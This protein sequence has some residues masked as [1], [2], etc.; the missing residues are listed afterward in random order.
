[1]KRGKIVGVVFFLLFIQQVCALS[2]AQ[3]YYRFDF[4]PNMQKTLTFNVWGAKIINIS[5]IG[6]ELDPYITLEDPAPG[7][8]AR[9]VRLILNL[10]E[11]MPKPGQNGIE[12]VALEI[13][14][15]ENM[16]GGVAEIHTPILIQAPYPGVYAEMKLSAPSVNQGEDVNFEVLV[17]NLGTTDLNT[18]WA[19]VKV[20]D[21]DDNQLI[22][23]FDSETKAIPS[24]VIE[25]FPMTM[26]T[27]DMM[28][29]PYMAVGNVSYDGGNVIGVKKR[30]RIGHLYMGIANYTRVLQRGKINKVFIDVESQ[31][32]S[33]ID[34]VYAT[35]T[36]NGTTE[37]TPSYV[38]H[39]WEQKRFTAHYDA[40]GLELDEYPIEIV[41]HYAEQFTKE[42]GIIS[43]VDIIEESKQE[44]EE[45]TGMDTA[46]MAVVGL[47]IVIA[48]LLIL[49]II[50]FI[51]KR[52]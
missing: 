48:L 23:T 34:N 9:T 4:E 41:L 32:N 30:F 25:K 19:K 11:T 43:V 28:S 45:P 49:I 33:A 18:V 42:D 39:G 35:V 2:V 12:F 22:K 36:I 7:K 10:P 20:Y 3:A 40:S 13:P 31:W 26:G 15:D 14:E 21:E 8:G 47:S 51:R 27:I 6:A 46:M 24:K 44:V 17:N 52:K 16:V 5:F 1:M 50:L 29:G 38:M 37:R